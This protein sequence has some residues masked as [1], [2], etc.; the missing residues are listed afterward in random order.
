MYAAPSLGR[1]ILSRAIGSI[2]FVATAVIICIIKE[3]FNDK[4]I[5]KMDSRMFSNGTIQ[6]KCQYCSERNQCSIGQRSQRAN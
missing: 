6:R 1:I 3:K 5:E 4:R 2:F